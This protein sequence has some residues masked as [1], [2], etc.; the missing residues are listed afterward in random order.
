VVSAADPL[1]NLRPQ[2]KNIIFFVASELRSLPTFLL[3]L[4]ASTSLYSPFCNF[5]EI[6]NLIAQ[7]GTPVLRQQQALIDRDACFRFP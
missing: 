6:H 1:H 7:T 5:A 3:S 2:T 4:F